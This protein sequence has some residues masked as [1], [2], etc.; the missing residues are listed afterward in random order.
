[1]TAFLIVILIVQSVLNM[2]GVFGLII[3]SPTVSERFAAL[4]LFLV[5]IADIVGIVLLFLR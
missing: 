1:M 2:L 4:F 3:G 5:L